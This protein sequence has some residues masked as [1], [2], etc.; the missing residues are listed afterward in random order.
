MDKANPR[1]LGG[2]GKPRIG[3]KHLNR[4]RWSGLILVMALVVAL[5]AA[6]CVT[7][8]E[9]TPPTATPT[10]TTVATETPQATETPTQAP[11]AT[12][13]PPPAPA[14]MPTQV[15]VAVPTPGLEPVG[16]PRQLSPTPTPGPSQ[17]SRPP[18]SVVELRAPVAV[19]RGATRVGFTNGSL[20]SFG[21]QFGSPGG[22][23]AS[24]S[25]FVTV[26][27][28]EVYVLV[29]FRNSFSGLEVRR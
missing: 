26:T 17:P 19:A 11:P 2:T 15:Q 27:A 24:A 29:F 20:L 7:D 8:D 18:P 4:T 16:T 21:Q 10:S 6:A 9:T 23:T 12:L 14:E 13:V 22:I 5:I 1:K 25:G 3:S 28:D